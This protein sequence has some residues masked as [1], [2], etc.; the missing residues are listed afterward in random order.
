MSRSYPHHHV[1]NFP[2]N[3]NPRGR[4]FG[5]STQHQTYFIKVFLFFYSGLFLMDYKILA[6][7]VMLFYC[8]T[9]KNTRNREK[10]E[11]KSSTLALLWQFHGCKKISRLKKIREDKKKKVGEHGLN[12]FSDI[13]TAFWDII[14]IKGSGFFSFFF[15][16]IW[17][18]TAIFF[19]KVV[20]IR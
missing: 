15:V 8:R 17:I 4:V 1:I 16:I 14:L 5:F 10:E 6:D 19:K 12:S 11:K 7:V 3:P 2:T 13:Y 18:M 20:Y 9:W